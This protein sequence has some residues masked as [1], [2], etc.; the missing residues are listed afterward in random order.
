MTEDADGSE[1]DDG[2]VTVEYS[3]EE[4]QE[5]YEVDDEI[6][7]DRSIFEW[8]GRMLVTYKHQREMDVGGKEE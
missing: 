6:V 7:E 3:K 4:K 2:C 5:L 8:L 1:T